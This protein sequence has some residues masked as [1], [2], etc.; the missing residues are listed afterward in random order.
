MKYFII[1]NFKLA[2][3]SVYFHKNDTSTLIFS[4]A[5]KNSKERIT[6]VPANA[7]TGTHLE[8]NSTVRKQ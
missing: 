8:P 6:L 5:D 1:K 3:W 4:H 7:N 2:I